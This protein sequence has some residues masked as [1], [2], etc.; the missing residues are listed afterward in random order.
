M[1]RGT[2]LQ[3][4][5]CTRGRARGDGRFVSGL[6]DAVSTKHRNKSV[7]TPEAL[8]KKH[9][10]SKLIVLHQVLQKVTLRKPQKS[11]LTH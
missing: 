6:R 10:L 7:C 9:F 2:L 4:T 8:Q 3:K 1:Q 11:T 5:A